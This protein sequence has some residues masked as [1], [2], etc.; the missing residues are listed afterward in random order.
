[1]QI[2]KVNQITDYNF[3]TSFDSIKEKGHTVDG[4]ARIQIY[5]KKTP[6]THVTFEQ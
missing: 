4:E 3:L 6:L 1:M 5:R 2:K